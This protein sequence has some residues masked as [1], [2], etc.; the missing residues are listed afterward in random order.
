MESF[1][2]KLSVNS[3][4]TFIQRQKKK[5]KKCVLN[6]GPCAKALKITD[7]LLVHLNR[8]QMKQNAL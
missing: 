8:H 6:I 2:K 4:F 3:N 5:S 1:A 7:I